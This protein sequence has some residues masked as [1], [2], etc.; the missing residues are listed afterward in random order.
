MQYILLS[1]VGGLVLAICLLLLMEIGRRLGSRHHRLKGGEEVAA[2]GTVEA[3]IFGILGLFLA[4]T[5]SG[6]NSRFDERRV[7]IVEEANK[8]S[9]VFFQ[10]D[11]LPIDS[12]PGFRALLKD[13]LA[14][15]IEVSH[16]SARIVHGQELL[17]TKAILRSE[18]LQAQLW[19]MVVAVNDERRSDSIEQV[20]FPSLNAMFSEARRRN[21]IVHRHPPLTVY[22]MLLA[23]AMASA[24]VAGF[25]M[26]AGGARSY[27][28]FA[29]LT[30]TLALTIFVIWDIEFPRS[31]FIR[32]D[33]FDA[34]LGEILKTSQIGR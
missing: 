16:K 23:M 19:R 2:F 5:F 18:G 9:T 11:L 20:L 24:L 10:A 7:L 6:A 8:I 26:S 12:R 13:Y 4:F 15:R 31:G 1:E 14:A 21:S 25:G 22:V 3:A 33:Y 29:G 30:L 27:I 32:I 28:H 34:T 17:D